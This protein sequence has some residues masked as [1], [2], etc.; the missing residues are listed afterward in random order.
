MPDVEV[1]ARRP[2]AGGQLE[3]AG[4]REVEREVAG[5]ATRRELQ[6]RRDGGGLEGVGRG[7]GEAVQRRR[8]VGGER[9]VDGAGFSESHWK[10]RDGRRV[11]TR[12][13]RRERT[14]V[15]AAAS[16]DG[17]RTRMFWMSSSGRWLMRSTPSPPSP[18]LRA[19]Q[20]DIAS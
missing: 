5:D 1:D 3:A 11:Q 13:H 15:R 20:V 6:P 9:G 19:L 14:L 16:T 18:E 2:L 4:H 12:R 8:G 7:E 17:R 10:E